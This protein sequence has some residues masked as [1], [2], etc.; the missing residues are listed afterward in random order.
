MQQTGYW[1]VLVALLIGLI[2]GCGPHIILATMY[3][4]GLIP[5]S[6][7]ITNAICNDGDALFP[8]LAMDKRASFW[9]TIFGIIP[10]F[11]I[12]TAFYLMG[13]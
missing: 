10:A 12:G 6:A 4:Q 8:I 1:T 5:F 2:P 9:A 7:L 11:I 3:T 13:L